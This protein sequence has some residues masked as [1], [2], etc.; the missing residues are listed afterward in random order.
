MTRAT[1]ALDFN[2]LLS[3]ATSR[4]VWSTEH[5]VHVHCTGKSAHWLY[6]AFPV[7]TSVATRAELMAGCVSEYYIAPSNLFLQ[8]TLVTI[9]TTCFNSQKPCI[10]PHGTFMCFV[11]F[12]EWRRIIPIIRINRLGFEIGTTYIFICIT[13]V[14]NN[15]LLGIGF[16]G[17]SS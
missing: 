10:C 13:S 9:R 4:T 11:G 7:G 8:T 14:W 6:K 15:T 1:Y 2:C 17:C 16:D 12:S 5:I 3:P